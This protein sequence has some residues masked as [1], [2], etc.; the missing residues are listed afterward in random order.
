[1]ILIK[2]IGMVMIR[3]LSQYII[4]RIIHYK[5]KLYLIFI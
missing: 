5:T 3:V 1:M 4:Y 2:L